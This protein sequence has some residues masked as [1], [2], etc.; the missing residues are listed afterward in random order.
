MLC[1][2]SGIHSG[3]AIG[4]IIGQENKVFDLWGDTINIASRLEH[5]SEANRINL[6]AYTYELIRNKYE[7]E[8][9]GKIDIKGKG[10]IDMYFVK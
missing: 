3:A 2:H 4:G 9:R 8:Y 5:Q 6:S 7:C 1:E 10:S